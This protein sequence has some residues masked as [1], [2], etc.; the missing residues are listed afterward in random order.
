M[1]RYYDDMSPISS[2]V[3]M[4]KRFNAEDNRN[5]WGIYRGQVLRVVYPEDQNNTNKERI[6][7]V[8]RVNNQ[9]YPNAID[10]RTLGGIFNYQEHIHKQAD[11]SF[12]KKKDGTVEYSNLDGE[13]VLVMFINGNQDLPIII[14]AHQHS[15]NP[16][17]HK[18]SK[19]DD[20]YSIHEFNGIE[21]E[22]DKDS[23][24]TIRH[25]GR[26]K[27]VD[28][29]DNPEILNEEAV[30]TFIKLYGNGD[31]EIDSYGNGGVRDLRTKFT[32]AD[33]KWEL[34]AQENK[35][36]FD[37]NGTYFEDKF[38]NEIR[39]YTDG[40]FIQD[41]F[42]NEVFLFAD[43]IRITDKN[44]NESL[45]DSAGVKIEV[46]GKTELNCTGAVDINAASVV[47]IDGS[48]TEIQGSSEKIVSTGSIDP[49]ISTN[50]IQGYSKALVGGGT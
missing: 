23:N 45:M 38:S 37:V 3:P 43:G 42:N 12:V 6:E 26:K 9:D 24:Y 47:T 46:K 30:G 13:Y 27:I 49:F 7:Y 20:V 2:K 31:F 19:S 21:F 36:I 18:K 29:I 34:Y 40:I 48:Q 1:T 41:K 39:M 28:K 25:R 17:Y 14:G 4:G 33:R 16:K 15:R 32:K 8:V 11:A 50:H 35:V 22:I 5:R 44:A 10:L